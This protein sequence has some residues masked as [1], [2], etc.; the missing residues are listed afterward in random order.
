[1][2][3]LRRS[4]LL[5]LGLATSLAG[6]AGAQQ[7]PEREAELISG[8]RQLTFEGRRAGEGVVVGPFIDPLAQPSGFDPAG[9]EQPRVGLGVE[10]HLP[11]RYRGTLRQPG[12][13]EVRGG[14]LG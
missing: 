5:C 6:P 11:G 4:S 8:I 1:M 3:A 10:L 2:N 12:T 14:S 9:V 7:D 13:S